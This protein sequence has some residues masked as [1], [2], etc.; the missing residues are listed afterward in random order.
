MNKLRS[1]L[2][3]RIEEIVEF[4]KRPFCFSDFVPR[5]KVDGK[6]FPIAYG[7]FRNEV[8]KMFKAN[9]IQVVYYSPQAF[10][11]IREKE[12]SDVVTGIHT[13]VMPFNDRQRYRHLSN[14]PVYRVIQNIPFGRRALHDIRLKFEV[15]GIWSK[16]SLDYDKIQR[17]N[18]I[19]IVP[20]PS[21]IKGLD[22]SIAVHSTDTIS[23]IIGC[24]YC[25][26]A[27]DISGVVRLSNA[28]STV[29]ERLSNIVNRNAHNKSG[30]NSII[31]IP[32]HMSWIVTMWHFGIDALITYAGDKFYTSWEV[33]EHAL[34]TA[35]SK[36]W[37]DGKTRNRI[38]KQEYPK[39][40][41]AE[42]LEEKLNTC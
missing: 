6:E 19:H 5:F 24:S 41:L 4:E 15:K 26:V 1:A 33:A 23:L 34:I 28:L 39:L 22:I 29:Q 32:D 13:G 21:R 8:S 36:E 35:Y 30:Q 17:S 12:S 27:I 40:S 38:E 25:P 31:I 16:L 14:D 37:K 3:K 9:K 10:Y 18:D 11:T 7:S 20:W 42:A 2:W